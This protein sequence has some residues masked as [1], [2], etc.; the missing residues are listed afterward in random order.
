MHNI[1]SH[2]ECYYYV[3]HYTVVV[4]T[5]LTLG[6]SIALNQKSEVRFSFTARN[7]EMLKRI[8]TTYY[9]KQNKKSKRKPSTWFEQVT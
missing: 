3:L 4:L 9:G 2:A 1:I 6:K 5:Y 8:D 7:P